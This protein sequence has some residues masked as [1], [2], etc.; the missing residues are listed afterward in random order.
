MDRK[1]I[2][3]K[4]LTQK[5][6]SVIVTLQ[7]GMQIEVRQLTV[8]QTIDAANEQDTKKRMATYL[9]LCCYVPGTNET[10]FDMNDIEALMNLPA[11]GYYQQ[12]IEAVNTQ[13][14]P[15]QMEEAGKG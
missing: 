3:D 12:L 9:A 1:S 15:E 13:L 5:P 6:R 10:L 8:G 4:V 11:G 7:D 2:R 14:L